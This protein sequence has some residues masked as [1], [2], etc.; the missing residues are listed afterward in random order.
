MIVSLIAAMAENRTIG[1]DNAMPWHLPADLA[2]FKQNTLNKPVIM[3]RKTYESIGRP[4]P[5]RKNIV[6]SRQKHS[7]ERVVWVSTLE[8]AFSEA[9][10]VDEV[11]VIGGGNV[12]Q[13]ALER[14]DRLYLT[15]IEASLSGD[16]H[17][18]DYQ[19][20]AWKQSF[21]ERH[22]A[23]EKNGHAYRF[24]ILERAR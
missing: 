3:G 5:G 6:I 13:Q 12:Y 9:G 23:D 11:M 2:W 1:A 14:A 15:H 8:Q 20:Y 24:E 10:A 19:R 18:P 4:L 21:S 22:E 16:T 17:F 7:D